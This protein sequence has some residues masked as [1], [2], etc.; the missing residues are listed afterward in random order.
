MP[1][2]YS[3]LASLMG[4]HPEVATFRR[5]GTLNALNLLYM[6]AELTS[7]ENALY[8][9]VKSDSESGHFERS[10]YHRDWQTLSESITAEDGNSLQWQTMLK[11]KD[12]L[13]E[14][15]QAIYLQHMIAN[16]EPPNEQDFKFLQTWMKTPS[17]GNV[18][19]LGADSDTWENYDAAELI[20]LK[21]SMTNSL[22]A[23]FCANTLVKW[24]HHLAGYRFKKPDTLDIH[25]NT[26]NYSQEG[27]L[28]F[29]ILIGTVF[30]S[31]LPVA[32]IAVLYSLDNMTTRL[33]VTGVFTAIFSLGLG[34]LTNVRMVE[35]FS[36]TAAFAAVQVVFVS[37]PNST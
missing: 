22:M 27:T 9:Q 11:V 2:G 32:S 10:I 35:I 29:S 5:F 4:A 7:L 15:N 31:L 33:I 34:L 30:A 26:V 3:R 36:A 25:H 23:R 24:Y 16:F 12:K 28:R 19:L 20:C 1:A 18:Y 14:Y 6:Q 21:P 17:M 13:S 8:K 37:S